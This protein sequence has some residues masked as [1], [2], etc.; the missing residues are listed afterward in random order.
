M[1]RK[2]KRGQGEGSI[3]PL[4]SGKFR[5]V[6]PGRDR[7]GR[8]KTFATRA[9]A[10]EWVGLHLRARTADGTVADWCDRWLEIYSADAAPSSARRAKELIEAH[11]RP[12]VG[13]LRLRD[14]DAERVGRWLAGMRRDGATD[15]QRNKAFTTLRKIVRAHPTLPNSL[16]E[17]VKAP[18]VETP[19]RRSL[20]W[21][22]YRHLCAVA[23]GWVCRYRRRPPYLGAMVR[24]WVECCLR[25]RELLALHWD[26]YRDGVVSVR[27]SIC[28]VERTP[29]AP[30]TKGSA[31]DVPLS[32]DARAALE[33]WRQVRTART[34]RN[35]HV[36]F[37]GATGEYVSYQA[38]VKTWNDLAGAAGLDGWVPYE[39]RHTGCSLLLADGGSLIAVARRMGHTNAA[40]ILK[41]YAHALGDDQQK[42]ADVFGRRF[43]T[44][45]PDA[46]PE[47]ADKDRQPEPW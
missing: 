1:A 20:T 14:L 30:K 21:D 25:P 38:L 26:D 32:P 29:K 39:L 28:P 46:G 3:E 24:V 45:A 17:K 40:M 4:P 27:R 7:K 42:L 12:G 44:P 8:S 18:K 19:A 10:Q 36:M 37:P 15:D 16:L 13:D 5:G 41:T 11:V 22:Q 31:R 35:A 47:H 34:D 23:D 43:P 6:L 2:K 9:E 33:K